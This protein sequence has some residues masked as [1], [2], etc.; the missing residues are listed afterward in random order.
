MLIQHLALVPMGD[1]WD[2][3]ELARVGAAL[4]KQILR[5]VAP[6]WGVRAGIS[7][8]PRLEDVPLGYWPILLTSREL[9]W[10]AGLHLDENGQPYAQ[11]GL[12]PHWSIDAS[13]A[14]LDLL[15]NPL[16]DRTVTA[17]SPR[18][19]Q[20]LVQVLVEPSAGCADLEHAY[21]IDGVL[22]SDFCSPAYFVRDEA[23]GQ[24]PVSFHGS[25]TT[26]LQLLPGGHI[27]WFDVASGS[28]WM[29]LARH[30]DSED[31]RLGA[32]EHPFSSVRELVGRQRFSASQ[33]TQ[34]EVLA[35][36]AARVR[37]QAQAA[38]N[39]R[40]SQLRARLG[41][42]AEAQ[43]ALLLEN[44]KPAPTRASAEAPAVVLSAEILPPPPAPT[45]AEALPARSDKVAL[46]DAAA[47]EPVHDHEIEIAPRVSTPPRKPPKKPVRQVRIAPSAS[48][49]APNSIMPP[50]IA[51]EPPPRAHK[52]RDTKLLLA[53]AAVGIGFFA[54]VARER[55]TLP[56]H[57][58]PQTR[59]AQ[60][61]AASAKPT[62]T[63]PTSTPVQAAAP[64]APAPTTTALPSATSAVAPA[65]TAVADAS[66]PR[67]QEVKP[68]AAIRLASDKRPK[69][70][71]RA[72]AGPAT[73]TALAQPSVEDLI[74]T[75][76]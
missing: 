71:R 54:L 70:E 61:T 4:Q 45:E 28:W 72:A 73:A 29:R 58:R 37:E 40:A 8:F 66:P 67:M 15:V 42:A 69:R 5:D 62:S 26:P 3:S 76:R 16:G 25:L 2:A 57:A 13:R 39:A 75:R 38:S 50:M 27:T 59:A 30:G 10:A 36:I 51:Q 12:S 43:P 34:R 33:E 6:H 35:G 17:P 32:L 74:D 31:R 46:A 55:G 49:S 24:R 47:Y 19:D 20:G 44:A 23:Q 9:S 48:A 65:P 18:G 60:V 64:A 52:A 21:A 68:P 11:V 56:A 1:G 41:S 63:A 53:A 14:C 7:A 22:V